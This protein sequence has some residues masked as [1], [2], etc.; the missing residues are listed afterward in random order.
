MDGG[1]GSGGFAGG[2]G[3]AQCTQQA[4]PPPPNAQHA[5]VAYAYDDSGGGQAT[6]HSTHTHLLQG[7]QPPSI[8]RWEFSASGRH[9]VA[10]VLSWADAK[11]RGVGNRR[12]YC[13]SCLNKAPVQ[14]ACRHAWRREG[15]RGRGSARTCVRQT[16]HARGWF[17]IGTAGG[18]IEWVGVNAHFCFFFCLGFWQ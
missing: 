5:V 6:R 7:V 12:H 18:R 13:P 1:G 10:G 8:L 11:G 14:C 2:G 15:Y 3:V 16:P 17:G 4:P 9:S